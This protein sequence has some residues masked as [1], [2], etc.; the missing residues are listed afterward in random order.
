MS[1]LDSKH[2]GINLQVQQMRPLPWILVF[3]WDDSE[4]ARRGACQ[5]GNIG[6][7]AEL[8]LQYHFNLDSVCPCIAVGGNYYTQPEALLLQIAHIY[9]QID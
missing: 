3:D 8:N 6:N 4:I 1:T 5:T 2:S 7:K 9:K